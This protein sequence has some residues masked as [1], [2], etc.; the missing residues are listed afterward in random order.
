MVLELIPS[1]SDGLIRKAKV[2][3]NNIETIKA[4]NHLYP[5]EARAEEAIERYQK[6]KGIN[7]FEFEGFEKDEQI[8][9]QE[10]IKNLKKAMATSVPEESENDSNS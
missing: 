5:L 10:R 3:I 2:I 6:T 8:K 9:N 7:T 4:V 1:S